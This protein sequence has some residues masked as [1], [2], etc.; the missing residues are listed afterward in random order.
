VLR[1]CSC[2]IRQAQFL[3]V[4]PGVLSIATSVLLSAGIHPCRCGT[5][6]TSISGQA[7]AQ[8]GQID[9]KYY[10]VDP[11]D[12]SITHEEMRQVRLSV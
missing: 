2:N 3:S 6:D 7:T 10:D 8:V 11:P 12:G 1:R 9:Y 5:P 4:Q